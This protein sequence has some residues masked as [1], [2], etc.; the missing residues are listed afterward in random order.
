MQSRLQIGAYAVYLQNRYLSQRTGAL[1]E[2]WQSSFE[3]IRSETSLGRN[4]RGRKRAMRPMGEGRGHGS[5]P[6]K[7][8][9]H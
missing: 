6:Q 9:W 2:F 4:T 3:K 7:I 8:V 5:L 1:M